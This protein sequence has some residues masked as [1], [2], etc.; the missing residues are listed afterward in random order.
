[1]AMVPA[2]QLFEARLVNSKQTHMT[3]YTN[4]CDII[5][6]A[7]QRVTILRSRCHAFLF[8][9]Q[10]NEYYLLSKNLELASL[11]TRSHNG[12]QDCKEG[13]LLLQPGWVVW[14]RQSGAA[15][16]NP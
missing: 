6:D 14:L 12:C 15:L 2:G 1:M 7:D 13:V 3:M 4:L 16:G 11:G 8:I 10:T 9:T 5:Q